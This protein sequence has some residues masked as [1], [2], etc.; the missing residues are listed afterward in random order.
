MISFLR[1]LLALPLKL[2]YEVLKRLR[3]SPQT[4][5]ALIQWIWKVGREIEWAHWYLI[6]SWYLQGK[7]KA[8]GIAAELLLQEKNA[9]IA[10]YIGDL[11]FHAGKDIESA[12]QWIR[13][14]EEMECSHLEGLL[15]L[16]LQ[17]SGAVAEYNDGRL[18]Q[19]ILERNDLPMEATRFALLMKAQQFIQR[20]KWDQADEV[21]DSMLQVENHHEI[22]IYKWITSL[23]REDTQTAQKYLDKAQKAY[24]KEHLCLKQA[25]GFYWLGRFDQAREYLMK[26]LRDEKH[27][28]EVLFFQ[29]YLAELLNTGDI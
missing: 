2:V 9:Y 28:Q 25:I 1:E 3:V 29:P 7:E 21:L 23:A 11:E 24:N 18:V 16:K 14:A 17:M 20:K 19:K 6:Y 5:L 13:K 22:H 12:K 27:R 26:G 15:Y 4:Q 10:C 8:R